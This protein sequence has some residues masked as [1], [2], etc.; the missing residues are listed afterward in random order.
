LLDEPLLTTAL[1][2]PGVGPGAASELLT[3]TLAPLRGLKG[4]HCCAPPPWEFLLGLP[5]DVISFDAYHYS[6][7]LEGAAPVLGTF[8]VRGGA[9]AWGIVPAELSELE[10]ETAESL[11]ERVIGLWD[12]LASRGVARERLALQALVTPACGLACL[13]VAHAE[14]AM[15]LTG[16]VAQTL[17]GRLKVT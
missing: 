9:I 12:R 10:R 8:L 6:H 5:L 15:S 1:A 11:A 4:L 17:R 16:Q 2:H 3:A 13:D 7:T 14:A